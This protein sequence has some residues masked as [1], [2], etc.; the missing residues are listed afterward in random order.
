MFDECGEVCYGSMCYGDLR[1]KT[2]GASY[3]RKCAMKGC[4][5]EILDAEDLGYIPGDGICEVCVERIE[6]EE[7][8]LIMM[9]DTQQEEN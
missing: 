7:K 5:N 3:M 2:T 4:E 6:R 9:Q 1:R 8:K